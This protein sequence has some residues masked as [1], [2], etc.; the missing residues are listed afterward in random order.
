[1]A[2]TDKVKVHRYSKEGVFEKEYPSLISVEDDNEHTEYSSAEVGRVTRN[3]TYLYKD[4][5]WLR[6]V[7]GEEIK[8][9]IAIEDLFPQLAEENKTDVLEE[10]EDKSITGLG[11]VVK[12]IT[13]ALGIKQCEACKKRQETLNRLFPFSKN[14]EIEPLTERE[15]EILDTMNRTRSLQQEH[16]AE[17]FDAYN[18]RFVVN[19]ANYIQPCNCAGVIAKM[20][21]S[22]DLLRTD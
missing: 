17:L 10:Q 20:K 8:L 11:D 21:E 6:A 16:K 5:Y 4:K 2:K 15:I 19:K 14:K 7:E 3:K 13:S 18:K 9:Q 1:M 12:S 22:L